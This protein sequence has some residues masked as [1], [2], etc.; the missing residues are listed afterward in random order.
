MVE[1]QWAELGGKELRYLDQTWACTGEVDVQQSGELL[2]VRAKQTDD[3]K[4]RSAT[5]F[6]A[7]QNSPDSLNPGALGD[8]FDRLGQEDGE[9]YLELR[10]EGRTYRYGLQRMSYE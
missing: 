7:V 1:T 2:A 6:F 5:L 4:G 3:V 10:T 9:H 8:H